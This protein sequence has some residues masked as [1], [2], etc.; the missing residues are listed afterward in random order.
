MTTALTS[1][2]WWWSGIVVPF[3]N[4]L[5]RQYAPLALDHA[6]A[7]ITGT[8]GTGVHLRSAVVERT[9][10]LA[11]SPRT[12]APPANPSVTSARAPASER[13]EICISTSLTRGTDS[14]AV[15]WNVSR[16]RGGP[17]RPKSPGTGPLS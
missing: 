7:S 14:D 5:K 11:A 9:I 3:G 10:P 4:L 15:G 6:G 12:S 16:R 13:I 8:P 17:L 1:A 2:V